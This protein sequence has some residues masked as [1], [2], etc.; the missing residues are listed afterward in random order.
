MKSW[1]VLGFAVVLFLIV[2]SVSADS[3]T[4][5]VFPLTKPWTREYVSKYAQAN[6]GTH[7][8]I[9]HHPTTGRAYVS[10]YDAVNADLFMAHEVSKGTGNCLATMIGNARWWIA[11]T[12]LGN[13]PP[14]M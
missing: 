13:T 6:V 4:T 2:G 11:I 3:S 7:V 12:R 9:A 5:S 10:Y 1:R 8:A 14:L